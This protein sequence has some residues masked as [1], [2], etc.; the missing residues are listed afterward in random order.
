MQSRFERHRFLTACGLAVLLP[1]LLFG[2]DMGAWYTKNG[3]HAFLQQAAVWRGTVLPGSVTAATSNPVFHHGLKANWSARGTWGPLHYDVNTNSLGFKD[4]RVRDVPM[5]AAGRRIILVGDSF[6]EGVGL[7]YPSTFAGMMSREMAARNTEVLNAAVTSYSPIT[8]LRKLKYWMEEEGLAAHEVVVF[9]DLSDIQDETFYEFG[10][11]GSVRT[12]V[13]PAWLTYCLTAHGEPFWLNRL[14][15]RTYVSGALFGM[16]QRSSIPADV[17]NREALNFPRVLWTVD[18]RYYNQYAV[19]GL[20]L[21]L[22]HMDELKAFLDSRSVAMRLVV[23][24]WPDQIYRHDLP[25]RQET[26]WR[27]WA[28]AHQVPFL[29]LFPDF[30]GGEPARAI[31]AKYFIPGDVHW[32]EAGHRLVANRVLAAFF[33]T[34]SRP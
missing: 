12:V 10:P 7:S 19:A 31:L 21:A 6:A 14:F 20:P 4:E 33:P 23:Y 11:D 17:P 18:S 24:P 2:L 16:L 27:A 22:K 34:N 25:S 1:V 30:I 3:I 28:D 9:L 29:D 5:R 32:N 13:S 8:Y 26:I 15:H